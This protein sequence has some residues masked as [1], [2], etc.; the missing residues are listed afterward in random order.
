MG[1]WPSS[2]SPSGEGH[3]ACTGAKAQHAARHS[4]TH[5]HDGGSPMRGPPQ[6]PEHGWVVPARK[7]TGTGGQ[8]GGRGPRASRTDAFIHG[9]QTGEWK[10]KGVVKVHR[11]RRLFSASCFQSSLNQACKSEGGDMAFGFWGPAKSPEHS[12]LP[13]SVRCRL[14]VGP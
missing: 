8:P 4:R 7:G 12:E 2:P 1:R 5:A 11:V 10:G 13:P 9:Q 6:L 14:R 3:G